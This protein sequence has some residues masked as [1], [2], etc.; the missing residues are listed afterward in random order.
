M[1]GGGTKWRKFYF[2][3][4]SGF[5]SEEK[6]CSV[7]P[8]LWHFI[9]VTLKL[10]VW[11]L[12]W[13]FA[14]SLDVKKGLTYANTTRRISENPPQLWHTRVFSHTDFHSCGKGCKTIQT[15]PRKISTPDVEAP[16][17]QLSI[18]LTGNRTSKIDHLWQDTK[19]KHHLMPWTTTQ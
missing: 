14:S 12:N 15:P 1:R 4:K 7:L 19:Q 13:R 10:R 11:G 6:F 17:L 9:T 16:L 18:V 2:P 3:E 5:P 8:V